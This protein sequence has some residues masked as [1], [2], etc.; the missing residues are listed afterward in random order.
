MKRVL[1]TLFKPEE[2]KKRRPCVLVGT[3]NVAMIT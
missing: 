3:E 1:E 2:F